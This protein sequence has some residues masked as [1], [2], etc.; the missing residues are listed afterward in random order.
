MIIYNL[1][2]EG[3]FRVHVDIDG[4]SGPHANPKQK[5]NPKPNYPPS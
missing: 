5:Q 1:L 2:A 3:I 4:L